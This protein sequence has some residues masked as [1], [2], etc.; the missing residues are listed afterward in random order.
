M[1]ILVLVLLASV[2]SCRTSKPSD[3]QQSSTW[4]EGFIDQKKQEAPVNPPTKITAY[5]YQSDTVYH[6]T[7]PC[8]DQFSTLYTQSGE[9][10]CHPDG[11]ITGKGDGKCPT[12][13]SEAVKLFVV[14]QDER[15]TEK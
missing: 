12:F 10:L 3:E 7:A 13:R 5:L 2:F 15:N 6:V 14:W 9:T 1:R 11:G 4:L 8:C